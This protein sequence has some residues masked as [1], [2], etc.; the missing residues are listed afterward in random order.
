M[1]SIVDVIKNH[2]KNKPNHYVYHYIESEEKAPI[3]LTFKQLDEEAQTIAY[4][5]LK[6]AKPGDRVL[7]L[8]RPGLAFISAFLACLYTGTIAVSVYPPR[9]GESIDRLQKIIEDSGTMMILMGNKILPIAQKL[10]SNIPSIVSLPFIETEKIKEQEN[11]LSLGQFVNKENVAFLQYTSGSTG[12]PKG[13]MV[14]H[15]NIMSN[16]KILHEVIGDVNTRGASWLPHFHDMGLI[17]GILLPLYLGKETILMSPSYFLQKPLRWFEVISTYGVNVMTGPNF[18]Y[19]LAVNMVKSEDLQGLDLS[20]VTIALTGAEPIS[21]ETIQS[22]NEKFTPFGWNEN[23][24]YPCYG[25]AETTLFLT[26]VDVGE[27]VNV[28]AIDQEAYKKNIIQLAKEK[29]KSQAKKLVSCGTTRQ[30]HEVIIVNDKGEKLKENEVGEIWARGESIAAGYWGNTEQTNKTFY[31]TYKEDIQKRHY[32]RTGDLGFLHEGALFV[33]GRSKDLIIVRGKNYYPQDIEA[34]VYEAHDALVEL[35]TAVFSI[36]SKTGMEKVVVIQEIKRQHIKTLDAPEV[37]LAIKEAV[38]LAFELPLHDVVLI[39]PGK[40]LKT[41]SGKVQRF[42]NKALYIQ[43]QLESIA[44]D[45]DESKMIYVAPRNSIEETL[46]TLFEEVLRVDKVG[47]YDNFFDLGGHSLLATQLLSTVRSRLGV[48]VPLQALFGEPT[49]EN[50]SLYIEHYAS[51]STLS[52]IEVQTTREDIQASYAQER[53]WFLNQL[54]GAQEGAYAIPALLRLEG[55]IQTEVLSRVF[56]TMVQRHESLRTNFIEKE[57]ILLQKIAQDSTFS[58]KEIRC[59]ENEIQEHVSQA[60]SKSFDLEDESLFRVFLY[61]VNTHRQYLLIH[62]HHIISDGW[63]MGILIAE[64]RALYQA[65]SKGQANPLPALEIQYADYAVWQRQHLDPEAL[66]EKINYWKK[67]LHGVEPLAL[68]SSYPRP[69]VQSYKGDTATFLIDK[70]LTTKLYALSKKYDAT[71]FMTLFS[72]LGLLLHKYSDQEEIVIGSP[73]ANRNRTEIEPLIGFFLN[74]LA[75]KQTFDKGMTFDTLLL[76]NKEETLEAYANQDVPIEYIIHSLD[77]TRDSSRSPLFTV[78]LILQNTVDQMLDLPDIQ[79]TQLKTKTQGSKFDITME[80]KEVEGALEGSLEYATDL[81][82]AAYIES[83]LG[84]FM[85]LLEGICKDERQALSNYSLLDDKEKEMLLVTYNDTKGAYPKTSCLHHLFEAQVGATPDHEALVYEKESISYK[86]LNEKANQL[87]HLLISKGVDNNQLVAICVDRSVDMVVGLL[88]I[89]KAGGAYVPIDP[90]YPKERI[91]YIIAD[92]KVDFVLTQ[93]VVQEVLPLIKSKIL[94]LDKMDLTKEKKSNP[95]LLCASDSLAYVIYTSG[96]TGQPKGVMIE[97]KGVVNFLTAMQKNFK[98]T[99]SLR[100]LA[101]TPISFDIHVLEIYLPMISAGVVVL[102][103]QSMRT[104]ALDIREAIEKESITMMQATPATWEMLLSSGWEPQTSVEMLIG[105][106]ALSE[107]LKNKL[108]SSDDMRLYNMYGPTETT[109]WTTMAQ[110]KVSPKVQVGRPIHNVK[111]YILDRALQPVPKGIFGELYIAGDGLA[112]GYINQEKL[113]AS[114][115]IENPFEVGTKLY[116]TGDLVRYAEKGNIEYIRRIDDQI[117]LRGFRIELGEIEQKLLEIPY[118]VQAVVILKEDTYI[119]KALVAYVTTIDDSDIE[120][121]AIKAYVSQHL[122]EYMVP[123]V[124]VK[125]TKMPLT[126][127]A[128]IDKKQLA[129]RPLDIPLS[130]SYVPA[131]NAIEEKLVEIFST[132]LVV[133]K[134][135]IHDNFFELGG[136]SLLATQLLSKIRKE[137]Q[138]EMLLRDLFTLEDIESLALCIDKKERIDMSDK[139]ER[140]HE[141]QMDA[142]DHDS[143]EEFNI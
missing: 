52:A 93:T 3:T 133:E 13:V 112:R 103:S 36:E 134:V 97:H 99:E 106:E 56:D 132:L 38:S 131:N 41:S 98:S 87:A 73:I 141:K 83:M 35:G 84:H 48:E 96:S 123:S 19:E 129:K 2:V 117:K 136:H 100:L 88:A 62:M 49:V 14:T 34:V 126:P 85:K 104:S 82:S 95:D 108:L 30:G 10:F 69:L 63:S 58:F 75:L 37:T 71:L 78:M 60:L 26:G 90:H 120:I 24:H 39:K 109:V 116:K 72:C 54:D 135:G 44:K 102:A 80:L 94:L 12:S 23:V 81:F 51:K 92:S 4:E 11:N 142:S 15:G 115:F 139:I 46:V 127:N 68:P 21:S 113:T 28:I 66:E 22:F 67:R 29:E 111:L 125:L 118:I 55:F 79:I 8:Y 5:I 40:L 27:S 76:K 17:G 18:A 42:K 105:G 70:N 143:L 114:T 128:K 86:I 20:S 33:C 64:V 138:V 25:M 101:V 61:T 91:A 31:A 89:L 110:M 43:K 74:T 6:Y 65:Y 9:P 77:L 122:P 124:V 32:L 107:S 121:K 7:M 16:M 140:I 59:K 57:G 45:F 137:F 50:L 53:L 119:N 1:Q 130:K 47:V